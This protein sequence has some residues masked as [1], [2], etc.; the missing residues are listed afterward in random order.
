MM[1]RGAKSFPNGARV[2]YHRMHAINISRLGASVTINS[3]RNQSTDQISWQD[4]YT[5]PIE[6]ISAEG[7]PQAL[8]LKFL[9]TAGQPHEGGTVDLEG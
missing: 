1:I 9:T 8:A 4:T 5:L 2:Q 3:Y 7:D 6:V